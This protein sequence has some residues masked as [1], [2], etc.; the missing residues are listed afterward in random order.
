MV[1]DGMRTCNRKWIQKTIEKSQEAD[2]ASKFHDTTCVVAYATKQFRQRNRG[3]CSVPDY[4]MVSFSTVGDFYTL[5]QRQRPQPLGG[6]ASSSRLFL[7]CKLMSPADV[8]TITVEAKSEIWAGYKIND[9]V[10]QPTSK[11]FKNKCDRK[12]SEVM[13]LVYASR[14]PALLATILDDLAVGLLV[15]LTP[16]FGSSSMSA[17]DKPLAEGAPGIPILSVCNNA[18]H[19]Q[20]VCSVLDNYILRGMVTQTHPLHNEVLAQQVTEAFP[21][22]LVLRSAAEDEEENSDARNDDDDD[23]DDDDGR[24]EAGGSDRE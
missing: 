11:S 22:L 13:T 18:R 5:K 8:P 20:H 9:D 17:F 14:H 6:R 15:V 19:T 1:Y 12:C 23:D 24:S 7:D 16:G 10:M 21:G 2:D 3:F 4:E